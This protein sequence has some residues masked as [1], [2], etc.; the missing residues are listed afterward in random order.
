MN[1]RRLRIYLN[2]HLAASTGVLARAR[3]T[4]RSNRDSK[5]GRVLERFVEE[6]S[7]DRQALLEV[8]ARLGLRRARLKE[9]AA[10]GAERAGRLKLNGRWIRYSPLSRVEEL[11]LFTAGASLKGRLWETLGI[12]SEEDERLDPDE[13]DARRRRARAQERSLAALRRKWVH[14][15]FS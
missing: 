13:I 1:H 10:L 12:L 15:A 5:L 11:E 8:M 2:D 9:I 3:A 4:V 14:E 7:E 6:S